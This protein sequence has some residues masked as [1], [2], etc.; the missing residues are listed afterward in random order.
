MHA[1]T[2]VSKINTMSFIAQKENITLSTHFFNPFVPIYLLEFQ[3]K[4][5]FKK[6]CFFFFKF[7]FQ[8]ISALKN[9]G[10]DRKYYSK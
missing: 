6:Q 8:I 1:Q 5:P 9:R 3:C 4:M 10:Q 2:H 7:M